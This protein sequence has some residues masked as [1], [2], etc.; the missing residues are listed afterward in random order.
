MGSVRSVAI[1]LSVN[2]RSERRV[3]AARGDV[4]HAPGAPPPRS[5]SHSGPAA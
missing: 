2:P 4:E 1:T 5:I 3:A